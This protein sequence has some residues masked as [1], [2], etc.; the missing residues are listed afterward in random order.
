METYLK[1]K[2]REFI[3]KYQEKFKQNNVKEFRFLCFIFY[4]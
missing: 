2:N 3:N 4:Y 1:I